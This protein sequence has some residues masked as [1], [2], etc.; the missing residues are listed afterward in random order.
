MFPLAAV[1]RKNLVLVLPLSWGISK[2]ASPAIFEEVGI[3][4]PHM[5]SP[6]RAGTEKHLGVSEVQSV[7]GISGARQGWIPSVLIYLLSSQQEKNC[8]HE[9]T[10]VLFSRT[11]YNAKSLSEL[12][13]ACLLSS[14]EAPASFSPPPWEA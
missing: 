13:H 3:P 7:D 9:V 11:F 8:S 5:S 6:L 4:P 10:V 1:R 2:E 12:P 14:G